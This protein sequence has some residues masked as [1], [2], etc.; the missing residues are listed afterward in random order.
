M[1]TISPDPA[2]VVVWYGD[3]PVAFGAILA[4]LEENEISTYD[5]AAI[6]DSNSR[7]PCFR[8]RAIQFWFTQTTRRKHGN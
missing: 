3:D 7:P 8:D 6:G 4:A 5:M 2:P 1:T